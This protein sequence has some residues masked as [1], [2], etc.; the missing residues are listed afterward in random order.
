MIT[1]NHSPFR[2]ERPVGGAGPLEGERRKEEV[3]IVRHGYD[4][5][6]IFCR[7][8]AG[9]APASL[10]YRDD[11]VAAFMD[12]R[13]VNPGHLLV[14]PS[15]HA[16]MLADLPKRDGQQMFAVAQQLAA[17]VRRSGVRC[18]GVNLFLADGE[19]AGQE[20]FHAHFLDQTAAAI[21]S[22]LESE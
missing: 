20:V 5:T 12:I 14:V 6:C 4:P 2:R 22:N 18:E 8:I 16:T 7:I 19:V 1:A 10:V 9:Q 11:V 3:S 15:A 13:P 17:A 21:H